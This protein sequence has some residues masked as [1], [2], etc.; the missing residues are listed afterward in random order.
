MSQSLQ[1]ITCPKWTPTRRAVGPSGPA[2]PAPAAS[3]ATN[4]TRWATEHEHYQVFVIYVQQVF[5]NVKI[6]ESISNQLID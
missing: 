2:I 6:N 5:I 3:R 4:T 1:V